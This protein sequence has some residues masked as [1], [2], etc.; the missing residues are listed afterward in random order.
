MADEST[1]LRFQVTA[2]NAD[3]TLAVASTPT[4]TVQGA[5]PVMTAAPTLAGTAQRGNLLTATA[6]AWAGIGNTY[7]YAWQ[8]S[9]DG[10]SWAD[11]TGAN[12]LTYTVQSADERY[13]L[14]FVVTVSNPDGTGS[15]VTA[16]SAT[17]PTA[18]PVLGT[19]PAITGTARR[20]VALSAD[21]GSW[22][23]IGDAFAFQWQRSADPG[24]TWTNSPAPTGASYQL[25]PADEGDLV[26]IVV[27]GTNPDGTPPRQR[28]LRVRPWAPTPPVNTVPRR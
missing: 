14:R 25:T 3:G 1:K 24:T 11:I 21:N 7:A 16:A 5:P 10:A 2:T 4:A 20:A 23:G 9:S 22:G 12:A 8:R 27:T 13:E 28:A 18:A 19:R 15:Q 26:R 6:G 17:V